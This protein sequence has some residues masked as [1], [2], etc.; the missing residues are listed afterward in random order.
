MIFLIA[1][2]EVLV[3]IVPEKR[4]CLHLNEL[5]SRGGRLL[6]C[7]V[8]ESCHMVELDRDD[9]T[10]L[11]ILNFESPVEDADLQPVIAVELRD[12]ITRLVTESELLR[13]A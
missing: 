7:V 5:V 13:V 12:Q 8:L 3:A 6:I 10:R 11:G 1:D 9:G 2:H 4:V